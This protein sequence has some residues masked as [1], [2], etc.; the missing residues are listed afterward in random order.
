MSGVFTSYN[1][2]HQFHLRIRTQVLFIWTTHQC[3]AVKKSGCKIGIDGG[4]V[5]IDLQEK[6][7]ELKS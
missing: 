5:A 3:C 7:T 2:K 4:L 1:A 6:K